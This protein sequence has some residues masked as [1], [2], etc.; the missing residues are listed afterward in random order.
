MAYK[1]YVAD[2]SHYALEREREILASVGAELITADCHNEEEVAELC[3]DADGL[4]VVYVRVSEK[5]FS[6]LKKCRVVVRTGIG[7][8]P[9][10]LEAATAHGICVANVPDY[11]VPEVSDHALAMVLTCARRIVELDRDV[12]AGVWSVTQTAPSIEGMEGQVLGIVG[13]GKIGQ[14]LSRMASAIGFKVVAFDPYQPESVAAACGARLAPLDEV[15]A[16]ADYVSVNAPL[17]KETHHMIGAAQLA[18]MKPS[19]YLVNTSRGPVVDEAAL[20]SALRDKVIAG[21]ALDVVENEPPAADHPLR[22]M[23]NVILNP[24]AAYYSR[25]SYQELHRRVA[26][27][28]ARVLGGHYPRSLVNPAV[29]MRLRELGREL[30]ED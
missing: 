30:V 26:E 3:R 1:V 14:R 15:V 21:A 9:I 13:L 12:H 20:I 22:A 18:R 19:V 8:D 24:H 7:V 2:S 10:D 16:G 4:I 23:K 25:R 5:A 28:V 27:E 17:T 11:C 29:K 6:A